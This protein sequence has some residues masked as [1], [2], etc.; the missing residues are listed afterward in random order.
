[1]ISTFCLMIVQ[2]VQNIRDIVFL[3]SIHVQLLVL[4]IM[5]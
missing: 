2:F 4:L 1:M 3:H 5:K